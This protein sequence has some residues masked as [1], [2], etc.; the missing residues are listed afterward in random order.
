MPELQDLERLKSE[1]IHLADEPAILEKRGLKLPEISPPEH[2]ED[3]ELS[4][5]LEG[6][7]EEFGEEAGEEREASEEGAEFGGEAEEFPEEFAPEAPVEVP[8]EIPEEVSF[9]D[10]FPEGAEEAG[11]AAE[12]ASGLEAEPAGGLEEAGA[13]EDLESLEGFEGLEGLEGFEEFEEAP[14]TEEASAEEIAGGEFGEPGLGEAEF[15]EPGIEG[16]GPEEPGFEEPVFEEPSAGQFEEAAVPEDELEELGEIEEIEEIPE[17][18]EEGEEA[19]TAAPSGVEEEEDFSLP[20]EFELDEDLFGEGEIPDFAAGGEEAE[21]AVPEAPEGEFPLP[22]FGEEEE[23]EE[24]GIGEEEF[25]AGDL[26]EVPGVSEF[27]EEGF[28]EADFE[29]GETP[30]APLEGFPEAGPAEFEE[31]DLEAGGF[32]TPEFEAEELEAEEFETEEFEAPEFGSEELE[33]EE[34]E[35]EEFEL[36]GAAEEE[37][38]LE[39][40]EETPG[41]PE[42]EFEAFGEEIELSGEGIGEEIEAGEEGRLEE[43]ELPEEEFEEGEFEID[44]FNLGDLGEEFG[45]LEEGEQEIAAVPEEAGV[46]MAGEE[47]APIQLSD[48]EFKT[49]RETL[50]SLPRN[51][52]LIIEEQIGERGLSGPPLRSLIEALVQRKSPKE[53]AQITS[54]ITGKR[55]R[56]PSQYEKKTGAAFE[57]EKESFAYAFRYRIFPMLRTIVLSAAVVGLFIFLGIRFVYRPLYALHLYNQGYEQL[58]EREYLSANSY[59]Q[60]GLDQMVMRKQFFRY[61]EGYEEQR[62]WTLAEEKY[63]QLLNFYPLDKEGTLAYAGLELEKLAN[64]PKAAGILEE[65][66]SEEPRDYEASLLLGDTYLEWGGEDPQKYDRAR[67]MYAVLMENYGISDTLLFRMLRYFIRTDNQDEVL[68]LKNYYDVRPK[69]EVDPEAYTELGGYLIDKNRMEDVRDVLLRAKNVDDTL[70]ETHYQ[71]ARFFH[72]TEEGQDEEKALSHTL[73]L[74]QNI[75]PLTKKRIE[76]KVDTHRRYGELLYGQRKYLD[77]RAQYNQGIQLY[78]QSLDR[79]LIET[80]PELGKIY[81]DLADIYYYQSGEYGE[82]ENYYEQAERNGFDSP[83][84]KYKQG[85]I[86]YRNGEYRLALLKFQRSAGPFSTNPN[87]MYATAN[88]LFRRGNFQSAQGYYSHLVELLG[89]ELEREIPLLI[90]ERQDH[91]ALVEN[92]M[93]ASNNLGVTYYNLYR[94]TG[95]AEYYSQAMVQFSDSSRYFDRL[96]RNPETLERTGLSNLAYVNQRN[97]LYPQRDYDLQIYTDIPIDMRR[98]ELGL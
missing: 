60:R 78:E 24:A 21:E 48:E 5:L 1:I 23:F 28:G 46:P 74:M 49:M 32:E 91:R 35:A 41:A 56:I 70:P 98:L 82:A 58:E 83:E 18:P 73:S 26:E 30:E 42:E 8:G 71:L 19:E 2:E 29:E 86:S 66:L 95:L 4:K 3:Q 33:A 31:G 85:F 77:A 90:D 40:F 36:P 7:G 14:V 75:S 92:L 27:E 55:I 93:R 96:T 57:A 25:G 68:N 11:P 51:L 15:E 80:S 84:M 87:L 16:P 54:R 69:V 47:E 38:E 37:I 43:L 67:F 53:I 72:M 61:A 17:F 88:T 97:L 65:F 59:F 44:E 6:F 94:K 63:E 62:Q 39:G 79:R 10:I 34:F 22:E 64:Y 89:R 13:V 50:V 9:E 76:M 52:K 45:V 20:E 12:E 81:A